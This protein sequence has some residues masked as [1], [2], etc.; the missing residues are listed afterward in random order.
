MNKRL[1]TNIA[2]HALLLLACPLF[3]QFSDDVFMLD[4]VIIEGVTREE[5]VVP[6]KQS[7][8]SAFGNNLEILD[9]PRNVTV[10][11]REQ[12]TDIS[13]QDP[14]DFSKLTASSYTPSNFGAPAN[15]SIRTQTADVFVNGM[16]RGLTSNGNGM[17]VN[18]NAVQVVSIVKGPPTV[19]YG[20]SQYVGGYV[21]LQTKKPY[22]DATRGFVSATVGSYDVFRWQADVG[23]P[24]NEKLA[25]RISYSGEESDG[26]F[27]LSKRNT[28][29]IYG[30]LTWL[31]SETWTIHFNAEFFQA[32]Y[33]E[34]IGMN[35]PTQ[36]LIDDGLYL[37]S[38]QNDADYQIFLQNLGGVAN[39]LALDL[40][41]PVKLDRKKRLL[42]PGDD[43]FGRQFN[44]QMVNLWTRT[45]D[46]EVENNTMFNYINRDTFSSYHYSEVLKNNWSLDNRTEFR[47]VSEPFE[48]WTLKTNAGIHLRYQ[49]V[50]AYNNFF[51]EPLNAFDLTRDNN[52]FRV[53][54][55]AF[56]TN[57][58]LF[59][60][61]LELVALPVPGEEPRGGLAARYASPLNGETGIS[62]AYQAGPFVQFVLETPYD[63][64]LLMGARVD[65]L[66]VEYE[67]PFADQLRA[68]GVKGSMEYETVHGIPNFNISPVYKFSENT[69]WYFTFNYSQSTGVGNGGGFVPGYNDQDG[70][71]TDIQKF[72]TAYFHRENE[73]YETGMK[74][75]LLENTLFLTA[76]L[77]HQT[78]ALPTQG[79]GS[80][81]NEINGLELEGTWQPNANFYLTTSYTYMEA[82]EQPNFL[83]TSSPV[84]LLAQENGGVA[85]EPNNTVFPSGEFLQKQAAP[86]H[87]FNF[88]ARYKFDSGLGF[89]AGM[90][91]VG[92]YNLAYEGQGLSLLDFSTVAVRTV[93]VDW[94]YSLDLTIKYETERFELRLAVLNATDEENWSPPHPVYGNGSVVA[95][96]PRRFEGTVTVRF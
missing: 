88:V 70:D 74:F 78:F 85:V 18:F 66:A 56:I 4:E 16:R 24:I 30:A 71:F 60:G 86:E 75:Q 41:N 43:S 84:D 19:I 95:D 26:Y 48:Q 22:F 17:P 89:V 96:P 77:Y 58:N 15:P 27:E 31:K 13:I 87:L 39:P 59:P 28:Q 83:A 21:D 37:P 82:E 3:G 38:I 10:V 54:D 42:A 33:T 93:E 50:E 91:V 7:F 36:A 34:N 73:L 53:P 8:R 62:R 29:A 32:D 35:R 63:W 14:R 92:P 52:L 25:Y 72:S 6:S 20:T 9:T 40:A 45:S 80:L 57:P 79:G 44:A 51:V 23:G 90:T 5:T 81:N 46:L 1:N 61:A 12:L 64:L 68:S 67:Q 2:A 47:L 69:S 65:I 55:S 94:Q 76:A 11:S 49:Y